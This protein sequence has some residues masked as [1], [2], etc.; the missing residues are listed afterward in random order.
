MD[1]SRGSLDS[2]RIFLI[3]MDDLQL[4]AGKKMRKIIIKNCRIS[5]SLPWILPSPFVGILRVDT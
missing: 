4:P 3:T 2:L 5:L 1:P